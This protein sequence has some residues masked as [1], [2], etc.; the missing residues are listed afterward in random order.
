MLVFLLPAAFIIENN[1]VEICIIISH[2]FFV[3][4]TEILNT[5]LEKTI[6]CIFSRTHLI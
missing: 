3:I 2:L 4:V 1:A 6:N 5:G